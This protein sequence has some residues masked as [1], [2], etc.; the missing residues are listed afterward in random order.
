M[1]DYVHHKRQRS[2][3]IKE[4]SSEK[5]VYADIR[6]EVIIS[7]SFSLFEFALPRTRTQQ[8]EILEKIGD[9]A[10]ATVLKCKHRKSNKYFACKKSI[11]IE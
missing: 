4:K 2:R 3:E 6:D 11:R 7:L 9:G 8:Y 5:F 10:F 1:D